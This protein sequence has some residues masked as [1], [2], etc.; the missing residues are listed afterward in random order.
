MNFYVPTDKELLAAFGELTLR[1]EHLNHILRMTIKTLAQLEITEAL[2]A[3]A[4]ESSSELRRRINKLARQRLGEGKPLLQLQ[5][6]LERCKRATDMR[7]EYVHSV[8]AQE[9]DGE[10]ARQS[11]DNNWQPLPTTPELKGLGTEILDLTRALNHARLEGF[12]VEALAG[13]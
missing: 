7:N 4:Y 9:L 12:L 3:T 10:P 11:S 8:W 1:H 13:R 5:A 6:L 2:D